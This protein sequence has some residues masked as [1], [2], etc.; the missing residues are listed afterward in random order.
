MSD[1]E[2]ELYALPAREGGLAVDNPVLGSAQKHADSKAITAG[3]AGL[4]LAC[5]PALLI[6]EE[7][8]KEVKALIKRHRRDLIAEESKRI[9]ERA[10]GTEASATVCQRKD[11]IFGVH[12][13]AIEEVRVLLSE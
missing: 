13:E 9:Y 10:S 6:D 5:E 3:L 12:N 7:K 2:R 11:G 4:L 1:I 8:R